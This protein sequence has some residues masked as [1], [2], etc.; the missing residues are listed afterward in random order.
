MT[1]AVRDLHGLPPDEFVAAR[2]RLAGELKDAG[3]AEEAAEV[4]VERT[5]VARPTIA[6]P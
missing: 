3:K 1:D 6:E 5:S 4:K 2:D